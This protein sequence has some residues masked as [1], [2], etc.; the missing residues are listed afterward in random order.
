MPTATNDILLMQALSK[1]MQKIIDEVAEY[2]LAQVVVSVNEE[3]YSFTE[4]KY[5]RLGFNGGFIGSWQKEV[6][7]VV[8]NHISALVGSDPVGLPKKMIYNPEKFQHGNDA[9]DRTSQMAN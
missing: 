6:A 9:I 7:K 5:Q 3:V 2:V 8:G 4:G 1:D